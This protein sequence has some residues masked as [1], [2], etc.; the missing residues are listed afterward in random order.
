MDWV[1]V[2]IMDEGLAYAVTRNY[3]GIATGDDS[4]VEESQWSALAGCSFASF[5]PVGVIAGVEIVIL[6]RVLLIEQL[7][8]LSKRCCAANQYFI[9]R[10]CSW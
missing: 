1:S 10:V 9:W 2:T 3:F 7:L 5:R 6:W 8:T 4:A